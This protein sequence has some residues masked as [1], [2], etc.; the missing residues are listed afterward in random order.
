MPSSGM[1]L[2]WQQ[3]KRPRIVSKN[4]FPRGGTTMTSRR[5]FLAAT[6]AL[7]AASAVSGSARAQGGAEKLQIIDAHG[8]YT[9]APPKGDLGIADDQIRESLEKN[10]L[11]L[12]KERGIDL[13][14]FSPRASGMGKGPRTGFFYDDTKRYI[15]Q[16]DFLT[17]EDRRKVFNG[18]A[19]KVYTRLAAH[20][21]KA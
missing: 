5:D 13:A 2:K 3:L 11:R 20:L 8:H 10:Q 9:T 7:A 1:P 19:K 4:A 17:P 12:Q 16:L 15:D 18:N 6:T 14:I 21:K